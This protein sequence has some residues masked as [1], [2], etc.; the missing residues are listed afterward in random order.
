MIT[1]TR[2]VILAA[3][4]NMGYAAD[5]IDTDMTLA[6]L[7]ALVEQAIEEYGP[8]AVVVTRDINN[9]YGADFGRLSPYD[10]INAADADD[11]GHF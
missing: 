11:E 3:E 4:P 8:D 10:A 7:M 2:R 6:D 9:R 5:Q 1:N